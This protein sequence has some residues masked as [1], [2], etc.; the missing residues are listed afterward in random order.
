MAGENGSPADPLGILDALQQ[1]P[2]QFEFCDAVRRLECAFPDKPRFGQSLRASDDPIRLTQ[3]PFLIFPPASV[4]SC[5]PG[6]ASGIAQLAVYCFGLFGPNGPLPLHLTEHVLDRQRDFGDRTLRCFLDMFHHRLLSL[7][8]AAWASA[9]PTV[10]F[11][12]PRSDQFATYLGALVG[13]AMPTLRGRDAVPDLAKLHYAGRLSAHTSNAEGLCAVVE[14]FFG[15]PARIEQF[16][17]QWLELPADQQCRLGGSSATG[18]L[19]QS[20]TVGTRVWD[21]QLKFRLVVGP[22]SLADFRRLLPSSDSYARLVDLVRNYVGDEF[23]WDTELVLKEMEVPT[24]RLG[25]Q[26]ELGWTS[27][28]PHRESGKDVRVVLTPSAA[29]Q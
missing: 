6:S 19:G 17:G 26:G 13:I 11:D 3:K 21:R 25:E 2:Y 22:L 14:S 28:F 24:T 10:Q 29:V 1:T 8:Y 15:V 7:F 12:R 20:A 23:I 9:Q 18:V 27:W 5:Q 16:F 4:A